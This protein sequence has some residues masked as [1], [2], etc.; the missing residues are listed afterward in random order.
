MRIRLFD[1][2]AHPRFDD[3]PWA[4]PLEQWVHPRITDILGLMPSRRPLRSI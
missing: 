4:T 2:A 3:L 1:A